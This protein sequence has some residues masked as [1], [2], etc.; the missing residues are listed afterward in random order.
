MGGKGGMLH[1]ERLVHKAG[2]RLCNLRAN[3]HGVPC[4][5]ALTRCAKRP[6][7]WS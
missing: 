6:L 1:S 3:Q 5:V 7:T 2:L 4:P